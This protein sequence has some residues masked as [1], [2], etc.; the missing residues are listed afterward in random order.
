MSEIED[1]FVTRNPEG[2]TVK[3]CF[4]ELHEEI[5]QHVFRVSDDG[6]YATVQIKGRFPLKYKS[7]PPFSVMEITE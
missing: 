6:N 1:L 2:S 4:G 3:I 5:F 7:G